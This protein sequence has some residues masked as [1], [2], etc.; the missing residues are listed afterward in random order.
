MHIQDF[1][2]MAQGKKLLKNLAFQG[3][4]CGSFIYPAIS[5]SNQKV[6]TINA[7]HLQS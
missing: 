6:K 3:K 4:V 1:S 2:D 5:P 7:L